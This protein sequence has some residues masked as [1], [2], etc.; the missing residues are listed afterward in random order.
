M[1]SLLRCG[2]DYCSSDSWN[3][4]YSPDL[5]RDCKYRY[6]EN[7]NNNHCRANP[8]RDASGRNVLYLFFQGSRSHTSR[9]RGGQKYRNYSNRNI[10]PVMDSLLRGGLDYKYQ[11]DFR[12]RNHNLDLFRGGKYRCGKNRN[13]N[14]CRANLYREASVR[15]VLYLFFQGSRSHASC[16]RDGQKYRNYSNRNIL[17]VMDS[18]L[19]GGLDYKYQPDF[20]NRNHNLDLFRDG[21]YRCGKNRNNN[22]CRANLYREASVRNVLYLF[23]QGSRNHASCC[24]DGQKYRNYSNRNILAVMDSLLQCGLDYKYQPDFRNRNHNLDLFRDGKY[25]YPENRNNNH[26]RANPYRDA[27]GRNVL[28]LFFGGSRSH[29]S[30]YR[31]GQKYRNYSNRNIL[32]VMDSLLQC[33]L[34]YKYQP[35]F[36]NRNHNRD[37]FRDGKYRHTE[38]R[39]NNHCRA[40]PYRDASGR[41]VLYLFSLKIFRRG[42][43]R[44]VKRKNGGNYVGS[45][46][47]L[48]SLLRGGLDYS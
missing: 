45:V 8:Y 10:L 32:P 43:R 18:L 2:L 39:N 26:C 20:R 31:D 21:K 40:S 16:C 9:Y 30:C 33:G 37:L 23:F 47:R 44:G 19:R 38:N 6:P 15:N 11:P 4:N 35:D 1:D 17:P 29:A 34:D 24:R 41:N 48:D 5:F 3:R 36:R 42:F 14:H 25:R 22:H 13:N 7:R 28:Y 27:S 12:N 46:L